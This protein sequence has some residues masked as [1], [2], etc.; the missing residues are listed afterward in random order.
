MMVTITE[1]IVEDP[2]TIIIGR[3]GDL[4][5]ITTIMNINVSIKC[6]C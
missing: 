5:I 4:E 2:T 6:K 3:E 1:A